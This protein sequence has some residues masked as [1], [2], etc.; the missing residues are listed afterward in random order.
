LE[1]AWIAAS[2]LMNAIS[3]QLSTRTGSACV[4]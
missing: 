4:N 1:Y 2:R 3:V